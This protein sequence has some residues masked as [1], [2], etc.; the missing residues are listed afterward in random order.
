MQLKRK[1]KKRL[2]Q[3]REKM[4]WQTEHVK[5][6]LWKFMLEIFLRMM[7]HDGVDQLKL[8]VIKSRH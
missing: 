5:S 4:L 1:R 3:C 7:L 6:G 8:I 2:V